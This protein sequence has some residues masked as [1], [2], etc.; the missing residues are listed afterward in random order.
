M[1]RSV[2]RSIGRS[3]CLCLLAH[4]SRSQAEEKKHRHWNSLIVREALVKVRFCE[5]FC[6]LACLLFV[7]VCVCL[8]VCLIF[9]FV[10]P[11]VV[12]LFCFVFGV[13]SYQH[14]QHHHHHHQ[15]QQQPQVNMHTN[16]SCCLKFTS[17]DVGLPN[18]N[19]KVFT[20]FVFLRVCVCVMHTLS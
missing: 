19:N 9:G 8:F 7:C 16:D 2:C 11:V 1:G 15:Q 13:S 12:V 18:A 4:R 20:L 6:L 17:F 14:H 3:V 5:R 10:V